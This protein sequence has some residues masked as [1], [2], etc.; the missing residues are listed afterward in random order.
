M[1][2]MV[3]AVKALGMET[4]LTLGMLTRAQATRLKEHG[5]DYYNHNQDT[6]PE[7]YG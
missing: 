1:L 2:D 5:L 6:S 3:V 4:C 7:F